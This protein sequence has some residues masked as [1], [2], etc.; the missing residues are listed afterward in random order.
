MLFSSLLLLPLFVCFFPSFAF[1][2]TYI[3]RLVAAAATVSYPPL[4]E[5]IHYIFPARGIHLFSRHYPNSASWPVM[6]NSV[7]NGSYCVCVDDDDE[8]FIDK[9]G[10]CQAENT[11][12]VRRGNLCGYNTIDS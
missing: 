12:L 1:C 2:S 6:K 4:G 5:T 8:R 11:H 10:S 3:E 9:S 7:A